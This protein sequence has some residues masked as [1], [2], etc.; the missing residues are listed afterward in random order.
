MNRTALIVAHGQPSDPAPAAAELAALALRVAD[1]LPGWEVRAATLAEPGALAAAAAA[2]PPGVVFPM[3]MA[4]GWFTRVAIPARLAEAGIAGWRVLEPFGCDVAVH[5]LA[6][7]VLAEAGGGDVV[8]AAHGS[9][10]SSVPSDIARHVAGLI[11]GDRAGDRAGRVEVGFIDQTPQL[12]SLTGFGA[13]SV[14]LPFFAAAGGH[15]T[16]DIPAALNEAGFQGRVLP[17][18]GLDARVPELIARAI[19]AGREVCAVECRW[20]QPA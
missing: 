18:L 20:R 19:E 15:V 16:E 2:M 4:G 14:C 8:L 3:F 10:K 1:L 17:P 13:G 11:A 6:R 12:A 9:F 5:D 7:V